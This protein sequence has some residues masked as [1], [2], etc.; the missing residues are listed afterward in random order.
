M[1]QEE[2]MQTRFI[3]IAAC[4]ALALGSRGYAGDE[5]KTSTTASGQASDTATQ[6]GGAA[7]EA[8]QAGTGAQRDSPGMLPDEVEEDRATK[9]DPAMQPTEAERQAGGSIGRQPGE[10]KSIVGTVEK[11]EQGKLTLNTGTETQE[12]KLD[13]STQFTSEEPQFSRD[14]LGQGDEVRASFL[15]DSM[16]ATEIHVMSKGAASR[17]AE[18]G[19]TGAQQ[20]EQGSTTTTPSP[21]GETKGT[22]RSPSDT[23]V[24]EKPS[25]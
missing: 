24:P 8:Q 19:S 23:A 21:S 15:G 11:V 17:P 4:A 14:Q 20:S 13:E 12:L 10:T 7:G 16:R 1:R 3:V 5:H 22:E 6:Q 9:K 25:R 18:P 2:Q